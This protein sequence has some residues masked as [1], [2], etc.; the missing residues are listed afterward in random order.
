MRAHVELGALA[1]ELGLGAVARVR[2]PARSSRRVASIGGMKGM[3]TS[4]IVATARR[5]RHPRIG[6]DTHLPCRARRPMMGTTMTM[7]RRAFIGGLTLG[8]LAAPRAAPAQ[9]ARKVYRI[10][11][12]QSG[13]DLRHGRAP[14][15]V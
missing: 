3:A 13:D 12:S 15:A 11:D 1:V 10:G 9:P 7:D 6:M 8:G 2:E 5:R 4:S 14:A